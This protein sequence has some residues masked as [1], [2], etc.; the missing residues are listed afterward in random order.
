MS[1]AVVRRVSTWEEA[2]VLA[3]ALRSAGIE[4]E[5]F[6]ILGQMR[7][8]LQTALGGFRVMVLA[9]QLADAQ[10]FLN[11]PLPPGDDGEPAIRSRPQRLKRLAVVW[12]L[13]LFG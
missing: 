7:W 6:D 1:L 13:A 11:A 8:K 3:S 9:A 2:V 12:L 4:A 10:A 5:V